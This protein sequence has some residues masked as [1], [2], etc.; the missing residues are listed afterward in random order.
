[1]ERFQLTDQANTQIGTPGIK[2]TLSGGERKRLSLGTEILSDP[3]ILF[4]DEPTTGLD[5]N[6]AYKVMVILRNLT[7][8]GIT[9]IC[10][11]HQ[12]SSKIVALFS[13]IMLMT[14]GEIAFVGS[15]K[16]KSYF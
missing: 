6:M 11:I 12:P 14:N 5:S 9:V 8:S 1:M 16:G 3:Q 15:N 7:E 2:K 10:T 13:Q 4:C